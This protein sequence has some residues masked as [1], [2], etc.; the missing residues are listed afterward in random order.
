MHSFLRSIGFSTL[1][2]R[3]DVTALLNNLSLG[4]AKTRM[5][6]L[7]D[8]SGL[9]EVRIPVAEGMGLV[10]VGEIDTGGKFEQ[11]YYYPYVTGTDC[12][13]RAECSLQ[14]HTDKETYAGLLDENR[15]GLSLIFFVDNSFECL[16]RD[17]YQRNKEVSS[18]NLTGLSTDGKVLLPIWHTQQQIDDAKISAANHNSLVEAARNGDQNAI[19]VLTIEDIDLYSQISRRVANEDIYSMVDSTFMP[20]GVECD[21]YSILGTITS[22]TEKTNCMTGEMV[23]DLGLDCNDI[24]FHVGISK[25]DLY[26]QPEPGRRFKGTIWMQGTVEFVDEYQ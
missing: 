22:V 20:S 11:Y 13:S 3:K 1:R 12:S 17:V 10:I 8:E 19:E 9:C 23:Y 7:D 21:Q 6:Q 25:K 18:V 2:R 24:L 14:R 4:E 15:V 5:I 26:G 16:E